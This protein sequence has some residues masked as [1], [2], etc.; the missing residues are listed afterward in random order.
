MSLP[1]IFGVLYIYSNL[2]EE[3]GRRRRRALISDAQS[4]FK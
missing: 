2:K 3:E 4:G 1:K